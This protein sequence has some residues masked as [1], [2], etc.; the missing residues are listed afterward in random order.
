MTNR[1]G[2]VALCLVLL[3]G[4]VLIIVDAGMIACA[5]SDGTDVCVSNLKAIA[6]AFRTYAMD[7]GGTLPQAEYVR[8]DIFGNGVGQCPYAEGNHWESFLQPYV[9]T[10]RVFLCPRGAATNKGPIM[11]NYG[12]NYDGLSP[13]YLEGGLARVPTP[14]ET[15]LVMD[16]HNYAMVYGGADTPER[17]LQQVGVDLEGGQNPARHSGRMNV[18]YVD[19]HVGSLTA[20]ELRELI[21]PQGG[22][23][24]FLGYP[25]E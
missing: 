17:F 10:C 19:G 21:P 4:A 15:M 2:A 9:S 7:Y 1:M 18:A 12:W 16:S 14:S 22:F 11:D 8:Y 3:I 24:A 6:R 5:P 25:M 13:R 23:C 20:P